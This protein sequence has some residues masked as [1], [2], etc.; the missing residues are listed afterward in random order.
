MLHCPPVCDLFGGMNVISMIEPRPP[1]VQVS[2]RLSPELVAELDVLA[3][4]CG[5]A[6]NHAVRHLLT[7]GL[8]LY[9][10]A[11]HRAAE[12]NGPESSA[13]LDGTLGG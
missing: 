11:R 7:E 9:R 4:E 13:G 10:A 1:S 12:L 2:F 8:I 6:R 5:V 3:K